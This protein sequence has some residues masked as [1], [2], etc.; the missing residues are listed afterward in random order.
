MSIEAA[1]PGWE[2]ASQDIRAK[3]EGAQSIPEIKNAINDMDQASRIEHADLALQT[4]IQKFLAENPEFTADNGVFES[5]IWS[6][7]IDFDKK[8]AFWDSKA[9]GQSHISTLMKLWVN[10][11][12]IINTLN[13]AIWV[14]GDNSW[15]SIISPAAAEVQL[16]PPP[17][18]SVEQ[19]ESPVELSKSEVRE[20]LSKLHTS[21]L[22][23]VFEITADNI[24]V[25]EADILYAQSVLD[26]HNTNFPNETLPDRNI[27]RVQEQVDAYN[28]SI[29]AADE[30]PEMNP[31]AEHQSPPP[32]APVVTV[33]GLQ[34]DESLRTQFLAQHRLWEIHF[35]DVKTDDDGNEYYRALKIEEDNFAYDVYT[36]LDGEI[37]QDAVQVIDAD[38]NDYQPLYTK[39][40]T[41]M[42]PV[43]DGEPIDEEKLAQVWL[44]WQVVERWFRTQFDINALKND[45]FAAEDFFN[46]HLW[47]EWRGALFEEGSLDNPVNK[48][49]VEYYQANRLIYD[50]NIWGNIKEYFY[51]SLD[52]QRREADANSDIV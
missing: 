3:L 26:T 17:P 32:A 22:A 24:S 4:F 43:Y 30:A 40:T 34:N 25:V 45:F 36:N 48:D 29:Q 27:V 33:S 49:G 15:F 1:I 31:L 2:W 18:A 9:L 14:K 23:Q 16:A 12:T 37:L 20:E 5:Q 42:A 50:G 52:G 13:D 51:I 21:Y 7:R 46:I 41:T 8:W 6:Q 11:D 28:Q 19:T 38:G 10:Y 39:D 44:A 47:E 35:N